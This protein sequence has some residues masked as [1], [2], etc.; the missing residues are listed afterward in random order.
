MTTIHP[1]ELLFVVSGA[2]VVAAVSGMIT[3]AYFKE[4]MR[5]LYNRGWNA[6]RRYQSNLPFEDTNPN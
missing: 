1:L 5:G 4:R 6:G 3:A 2:L